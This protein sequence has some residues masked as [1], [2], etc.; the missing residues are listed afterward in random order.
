M[1][2]KTSSLTRF[3]L[4]FRIAAAILPFSAFMLVE[5]LGYPDKAAMFPLII[6]ICTVGL[7]AYIMFVSYWIRR[8]T[9]LEKATSREAPK[10]PKDLKAG[11]I[12]GAIISAYV[13]ASPFI[14][15]AFTTLLFL[16]T[17]F[18]LFGERNKLALILIPAT[19][20]TV[21]YLFFHYLLNVRI[22]FLPA[23][24]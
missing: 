5:A 13:L 18:F 3:P 10:Q 19:V 21:V 8:R 1:V 24:W 17:G 15:F 9:M 22:P 2:Q 11:F 4:D 20:V 6:L 23:L 16:A 14:G 12:F 7:S